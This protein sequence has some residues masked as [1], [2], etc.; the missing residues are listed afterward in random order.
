MSKLNLLT[1]FCF[2]GGAVVLVFQ[3]VSSMMTT[4]VITWETRS[5]V[6]HFGPERFAWVEEIPV[7]FLQGFAEWVVTMQVFQLLFILG[8]VFLVLGMILRK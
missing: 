2:L 3:A 1:L 5:L 7:S 6:T 4:G 8:A